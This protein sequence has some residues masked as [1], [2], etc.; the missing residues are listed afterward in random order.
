MRSSRPSGAVFAQVLAVLLLVASSTACADPL[1]DAAAAEMGLEALSPD[2]LAT[3]EDALAGYRE[4]PRGPALDPRAL[5]GILDGVDRAV[6]EESLWD[7][8]WEWL[9]EKLQDLGLNID[10]DGSDPM[11]VP[12]W[13]LELITLG[14]VVTVLAVLINELRLRQWRRRVR[15]DPL[16]GVDAFHDGPVVLSLDDVPG[17]PRRDQPGA[18]LRIVLAALASRG[19]R[20][21][22]DGATH[23][24]IASR[25]NRVGARL[26]P[27]LGRL[28]TMAELARYS[29]AEPDG[30]GEALGT[31]RA[32]LDGLREANPDQ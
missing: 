8:F 31:G 7:R 10:S 32:I 17:L 21:G 14:L 30:Q 25:A 20:F 16:A 29:R 22:G 19:L 13:F 15:P 26:G 12:Q 5:N 1:A 18:V 28:A 23:R 9:A 24:E 3:L 6:E 2:Q 11:D 27:P 4:P